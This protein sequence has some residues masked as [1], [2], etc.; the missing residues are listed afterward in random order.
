MAQAVI[1]NLTSADVLIQELY[2]TV[3]AN[4]SIT[5]TDREPCDLLKMPML[6]AALTAAQV[7]LSITYTPEEIASGL[8]TPPD[9]VQAVDMAPVAATDAASGLVLIRA[10]FP[11]GVGGAPDDVQVYA[12]GALPFKFRAVDVWAL[13]STAVG[14]STLDAYTQAGGAG[15]LLGSVPSAVTGRN[16]MTAPLATAVATP[17]ATEGLFIRRS[18]SGV[19]GEVFILARREN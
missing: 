6:L 4:G 2:A 14:A 15:T 12:A 16:A 3:P 11:A 17:G 10:E 19:A 13:V 8:I 5:V 18:D 1:T 7:S 9:A